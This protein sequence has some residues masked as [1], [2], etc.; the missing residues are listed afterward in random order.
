MEKVKSEKEKQYYLNYEV[1]KFFGN[2]YKNILQFTGRTLGQGGMS[3]VYELNINGM[4]SAAKIIKVE[5]DSQGRRIEDESN[6]MLN[7]ISPY[8]IKV[9]N[10]FQQTYKDSP[11]SLLIMEKATMGNMSQVNEYFHKDNGSLLNRLLYFPFKKN[12]DDNFLR[13]TINNIIKGI[14]LMNRT[15]YIHFDIKLKNF[16]VLKNFVTKLCD[17]NITRN[18]YIQEKTFQVPGGTK[19]Y[20]TPEY[21][22]KE[23]V[24][25]DTALKQDYFSLGV[26]LYILIYGNNDFINN[27]NNNKNVGKD[28]SDFER[29]ISNIEN[30]IIKIKSDNNL[31][32]FLKD[33]LI[34]LIQINPLNRHHLE[35]IYRNKWINDNQNQINDTVLDFDNDEEKILIEFQKNDCQDKHNKFFNE[36]KI[37]HKN[38]I[39]NNNNNQKINQKRFVMKIQQKKY[40]RKLKKY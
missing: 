38:F 28:L 35:N 20:C 7:L 37:N 1:L 8:T 6:I 3:E 33:L 26:S 16:L 39:D 12:I 17:F 29:L 27:S 40:R 24:N 5:R 14:E 19:G 32:Y 30:I 22:A 34:G 25:W 31:D 2:K 4:S 13:Y 18:L 36:E 11:Y 15:G 9:S 10:I 23:K 21:T